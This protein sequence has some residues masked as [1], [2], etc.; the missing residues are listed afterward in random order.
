VQPR[1]TLKTIKAARQFSITVASV[2]LAVSSQANAQLSSPG[3]SST[4]YHPDHPL[5]PATL[6]SQ[7]HFSDTAQRG[8]VVVEGYIDYV[9][10]Q[11]SKDGKSTKVGVEADGDFHFEMQSTNALRGPGE[12]PN[13]LVCE[14]DPPWQLNGWNALSQISRKNPASYRKA[15]VYGW[16]RFGTE[17]HHSGT[18]TYQ[19]ANGR[20]INGHWEVHPVERIEA[21]DGRGPFTIGPSA[22]VGSWPIAQ[23]YKVVNANFAKT[24]PSNYAKLTGKVER[25][26]ASADKSGDVDVWVRTTPQRRYIATIPQYYVSHFDANSQSVTFLQLPNFAGVHFLLQPSN[27]KPHTFYGL[28]NWKFRLGSASPALQPVET[29]K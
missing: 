18:R 6:L 9:A 21:I 15:R 11:I 25:I 19:Y 29:I 4:A 24:G 3:R 23:R 12:S 8:Y 22:K 5:D 7:E 1:V 2:M 17:L 13:G 20:T 16:L 26:A 27:S 10:G 28:R 14:I